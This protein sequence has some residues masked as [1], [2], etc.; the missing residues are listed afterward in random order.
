VA[1][2]PLV[3]SN[4]IHQVKGFEFS[5]IHCG[6]KKSAEK[7]D[8]GLIY[9]TQP[10]TH[11]AGLFTINR[12]HAPCVAIG[13]EVRKTQKARAILVNSGCANAYTGEKGMQDARELNAHLATTLNI[14]AEHIVPSSTGVIGQFLPV[15][16]M[17]AAFP[18]L[19]QNKSANGFFDVAQAI[20]TT[21]TFVKTFGKEITLSGKPVRFLGMAKGAGMIQ[22]N[23]AT[24][25]A[26]VVTD[27]A[28]TPSAL[29][30]ALASSSAET[31]NAITV[32]GEM[33]TNDT[34]VLLANGAANNPQI[35]ETSA[36]FQ[37]FSAALTEVCDFL[38]RQIVRDG[39]GVTKFVEL[40]V[41][42][43]PHEE[44]LRNIAF[45]IANSYLVRTA[46]AGEDANWGRIMSAAGACAARANLDVNFDHG[47]IFFNDVAVLKNGQAQGKEA[48]QKAAAFMKQGEF[49][50]RVV[51]GQAPTRV[52]LY[53]GDLTAEYVA[54]NANYRT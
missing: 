27:A 41:E 29:Q 37:I 2:K 36:D 28:I 47:S 39:E 8:L 6:I 4:G 9:S 43:L 1:L 35:T 25:L 52:R 24:M 18:A 38:A 15:E 26:Y 14:L 42:G 48:E 32:D 21:D 10:N 50:L 34:L 49:T 20:C 53:T 45:A 51:L 44:T 33:S 16:K 31:F 46:I 19:I 22:P 40:I 12:V 7:K 17:K 30:Q 3:D 13:K 5:G 54:I 23:M 11:M